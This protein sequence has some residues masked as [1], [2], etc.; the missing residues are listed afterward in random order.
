MSVTFISAQDALARM[1]IP[2]GTP[3]GFCTLIDARSEDE[4]AL[5]HLPNAINWPRTSSGKSSHRTIRARMSDQFAPPWISNAPDSAPP[6]K[7][8]PFPPCFPGLFE[9]LRGN[10]RPSKTLVFRV[11]E[12]FLRHAVQQA[13]HCEGLRTPGNSTFVAPVFSRFDARAGGR[14]LPVI[15]S[16]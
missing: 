6:S 13:V 10:F 3:G 16:F 15:V 8:K 5:D 2:L 14:F 7:N 4:Y 9:S 12:G 1:A 11:F